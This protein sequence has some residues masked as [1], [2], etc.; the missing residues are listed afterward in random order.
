MKSNIILS[1]HQ[2][3]FL[4]Y[5]GFFNKMKQSDIFIIRDEVLYI[6]KEYHNR[7]RIRINSHDNIKSPKSKWISVPVEDPNDFIKY[8]KIKKEAR[9]KNKLWNKILLNEI[10]SSYQNASYFKSF[11]PEL[12]KIFYNSDDKLL[13][14]NM[15]ITN[16]LK[17]AFNIKTKI[18]LASELKLKPEYYEKS[19]ASEDLAKICEKLNADIYLSGAG[20][21][22]YLNLEPFEKRGIEVKFQD[23]KHPI[24]RQHLPGFLP[25]M[26]SIDALFC[27]GRMPEAEIEN[28]LITIN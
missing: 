16:F 23:Y 20:G 25:Y 24:Y 6:K 1:A 3:N 9:I 14:L 11:F 4:P 15:K 26:S 7:N 27:T 17:S 13:A 8:A 22:T 18:I 21:K 19:S 12:E 28:K 5:L 2:P 10:K